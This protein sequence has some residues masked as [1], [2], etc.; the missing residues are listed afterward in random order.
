MQA[1]CWTSAVPSALSQRH[2]PAGGGIRGTGRG[3]R[4]SHPSAAGL[5]VRRPGV[6]RRG[7]LLRGLLHLPVQLASRGLVEPHGADQATGLHR[8]QKPQGAHSIHVRGVL[9][10][11][12]RNLETAA[13]KGPR[14]RV[15]TKD[16]AGRG[17]ATSP[18]WRHQVCERA[19]F[20]R[21]RT[22]AGMAPT[23]NIKRLENA[24]RNRWQ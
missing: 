18:T 22:R 17:P 3:L 13:E 19:F 1:R 14:D 7:L 20:S 21:S 16:T 9:S 12:K 15:G 4:Q 5:T 11:V 2:L 8:I 24:S 10:Q 6:E 23:S